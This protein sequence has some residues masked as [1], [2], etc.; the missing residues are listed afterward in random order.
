MF[1]FFKMKFPLNNDL[2]SR[3]PGRAVK[4]FV[5]RGRVGW[6]NLGFA[7][8][9]SALIKT[10]IRGFSKAKWLVSRI[11]TR[12]C[13]LLRVHYSAYTIFTTSMHLSANLKSD[14]KL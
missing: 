4:S 5:A 12:T 6:G 2:T 9:K 11:L 8:L 7:V 3:F 13:F 10:K 1:I 14:C